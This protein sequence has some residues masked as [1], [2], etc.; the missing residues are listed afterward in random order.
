MT[1]MKRDAAPPAPQAP[2]EPVA[3]PAPDGYFNKVSPEGSD[4][5]APY[6][7]ESTV[8]AAL[9]A[10]QPAPVD[11][12][13]PDAWS[14]EWFGQK[15]DDPAQWHRELVFH[16]PADATEYDGQR[17]TIRPLFYHSAP[18][19][20]QAV[21]VDLIDNIAAKVSGGLCS[22]TMEGKHAFLRDI[23]A[24]IA[25]APTPSKG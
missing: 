8:R 17:R 4:Y 23:L 22:T 14:Y 6:W 15:G 16:K 18:V 25:A 13:V 21:P 24:L 20:A 11:E 2:A 5:D 3:L 1:E 19:E 7:E 10:S 12:R 9:A